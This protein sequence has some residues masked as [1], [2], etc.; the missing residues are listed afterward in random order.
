MVLELVNICV[1]LLLIRRAY[2]NPQFINAE[3][4]YKFKVLPPTL[5]V[6]PATKG[7]RNLFYFQKL[8]V[9]EGGDTQQFSD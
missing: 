8:R 9:G 7:A 6:C 2:Q 4:N 3:P 5:F 1:A